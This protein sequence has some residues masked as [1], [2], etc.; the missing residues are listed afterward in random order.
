MGLHD[1]NVLCS[2]GEEESGRTP[3]P[4]PPPLFSS[5]LRRGC[6][7]NRAELLAGCVA[8]SVSCD[9]ALVEKAIVEGRDE[10]GLHADQMQW[11]CG[12]C[13]MTTATSAWRRGRGRG[14]GGEKEQF[15]MNTAKLGQQRVASARYYKTTFCFLAFERPDIFHVAINPPSNG[16]HRWGGKRRSK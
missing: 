7:P 12:A 5:F 2:S 9:A 13:S 10:I 16:D 1:V 3:P 14:R 4:L 15:K 8:P 11:G 6:C